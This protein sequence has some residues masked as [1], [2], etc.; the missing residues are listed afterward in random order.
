MTTA[1][2]PALPAGPAALWM[3]RHRAVDAVRYLAA[4]L[5][6]RRPGTLERLRVDAEA[7]IDAW[8]DLDIHLVLA[9]DRSI[10]DSGCSTYGMY[11][12]GTRPPRL[13]IASSRSHGRNN[14]TI[15]H[16]LAHHLQRTDPDW[17]G[18]VLAEVS[19][20]QA[21]RL[22]HRVCDEFASVLLLPDFH[23]P[24]DRHVTA[25][26]LR[27]VHAASTASRAA[28]VVRAGRFMRPQQVS[29]LVAPDNE[30]T[31]N[32]TR[33]DDLAPPPRGTVF[34]HPL[35]ERARRA[36]G[37]EVSGSL[38]FV[39]RT[40]T[41]RDG[42]TATAASDRTGYTFVVA[43]QDTSYGQRAEWST[44]TLDCSCGAEYAARNTGTCHRCN[45]PLCPECTTCPCADARTAP[46]TRCYLALSVADR[47][48]GRTEH[49]DCN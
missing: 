26:L 27:E 46:C 19:Q 23:W 7:E 1:G 6:H 24:P 20:D 9:T 31:F 33:G 44:A 30:I 14:F 45:Q 36:G 43:E 11:Q 15:L 41:T 3:T 25:G 49:A 47:A 28:L 48:A 17:R 38:G 13:V 42:L 32:H 22:E 21:L 35:I 34:A 39:Y 18:D 4:G 12:S 37:T 5:D 8:D 2:P 16:E 29:F 40:G 10:V